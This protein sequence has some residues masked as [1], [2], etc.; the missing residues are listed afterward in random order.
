MEK[1]YLVLILI[2]NNYFCYYYDK[3]NFED[4]IYQDSNFTRISN[5]SQDFFM[6]TDDRILALSVIFTHHQLDMIGKRDFPKKE[7]VTIVTDRNEFDK[8]L[9]IFELLK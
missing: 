6:R 1:D 9:M 2:G 4:K 5:R 3:S 7:K 8:Y